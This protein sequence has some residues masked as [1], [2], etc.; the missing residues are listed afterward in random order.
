MIRLLGVHVDQEL[1]EHVHAVGFA[2]APVPVD[3]AEHALAGKFS[4][5]G[6]GKGADM[7]IGEWARVNIALVLA[8]IGGLG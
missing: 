3:P 5:V 2:P 8:A 6:A 4:H 1:V 7:G